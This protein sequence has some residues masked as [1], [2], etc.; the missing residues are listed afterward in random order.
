MARTLEQQVGAIAAGDADAMRV[1]YEALSGP[2][3]R[4]ALGALGDR[5]A[6]E[7]AL[8]ETMLAIWQG[9][10]AFRGE[11]SARVWAFA[12]LGR[13]IALEHRRRGRAPEL[14]DP[15]EV[16]DAATA[17]AGEE[18]LLRR[19][20]RG[21][22]ELLRMAYVE[23]LSVREMS[24]LLGIPEGTVKSRLSHAR[25]EARAALAAE[26]EVSA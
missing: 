3:F 18:E 23:G 2:L 1:L 26:R 6:A 22:R 21:R 19:V 12:I 5:A 17:D 16:A 11:S 14:S 13:R 25:E 10:G 9:A 24:G 15:P 4:A 20:T 7:D 8:Q